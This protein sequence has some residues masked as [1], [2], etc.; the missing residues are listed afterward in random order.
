VRGRTSGQ[1]WPL[2]RRAPWGTKGLTGGARRAENTTVGTNGG[3]RGAGEGA[4]G[5]ASASE[6]IWG[7]YQS[8]ELLSS[9]A[10]C[11]RGE[12]GTVVVGQLARRERQVASMASS[13]EWSVWC[14]MACV[15]SLGSDDQWAHALMAVGSGRAQRRRLGGEAAMSIGDGSGDGH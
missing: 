11:K 2:Y 10:W 12:R 15:D 3:A 6:P 7:L 5:W 4:R 1:G 13:E 14:Q 8:A 9:C